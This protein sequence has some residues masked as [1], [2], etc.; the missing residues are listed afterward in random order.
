MN[1]F[2]TMTKVVRVDRFMQG[3]KL[4]EGKVWV[5]RGD[6]V[7]SEENSPHGPE[8]DPNHSSYELHI[9]GEHHKTFMQRQYKGTGQ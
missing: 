6:K 3:P 2:Y 4:A 9:F 5:N 8:S 7:W 1:A